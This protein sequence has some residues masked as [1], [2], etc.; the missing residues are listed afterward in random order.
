MKLKDILRTKG[1]AVVNVPD[2]ASVLAAVRAMVAARVGSA[3]VFDAAGGV[4]GIVTERDV[5][6]ATAEHD[7]AVCSLAVRDVMTRDVLVAGPDDTVDY[8]LSLM[9][10]RRMRHV[11]VVDG[12]KVVGVVSIGDAVRAKGQLAEVE[13]HHLNDYI[14]GKYPG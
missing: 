8:V 13:V 5:L 6:K 9:T 4:A 2:T 1:S 7:Q 10:E 3:L 14:S 11:P 12:G